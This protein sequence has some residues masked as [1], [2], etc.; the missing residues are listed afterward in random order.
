MVCGGPCHLSS[1]RYIL[2]QFGDYTLYYD[3][4]PGGLPIPHLAPFSPSTQYAELR[5]SDFDGDGFADVE[6]LMSNGY[7]DVYYGSSSGLGSVVE[8]NGV[9]TA[10]GNDGKFLS[11][12]G[13]GLITVVYPS[14][15]MN[16]YP[17]DPELRIEVF[18]G[19]IGG[20]FDNAVPGVQFDDGK[21]DVAC[22][23]LDGTTRC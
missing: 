9:P 14:T 23:L 18:D 21:T 6:G 22:Y 11:L 5:S 12:S 20:L 4:V 15:E 1:D 3:G 7:V 17:N 16:V 10:D 8:M 19:D 2:S 13:P